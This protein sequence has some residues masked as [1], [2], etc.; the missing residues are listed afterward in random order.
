[1]LAVGDHGNRL[2]LLR[3]T[4]S[5]LPDRSLLARGAQ[6]VRRDAD[7]LI[8]HATKNTASHLTEAGL[9]RRSRSYRRCWRSTSDDGSL[10][11]AAK[12]SGQYCLAM[13]GGGSPG[14]GV[15]GRTRRLAVGS[16]GDAHPPGTRPADPARGR[17]G[18]SPGRAGSWCWD[19]SA[20]S[21]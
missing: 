20:R 8:T 7:R 11:A 17:S 10:I 6:L 1:M 19:S 2:A 13:V 9:L 16:G 3:P 14:G 21:G 18:G 5:L 12:G 15:G 4:H